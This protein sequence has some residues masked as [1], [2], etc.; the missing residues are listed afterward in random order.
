VGLNPFDIPR[1]FPPYKIRV[2]LV[3]I[4]L[5]APLAVY[6]P[7]FFLFRFIPCHTFPDQLPIAVLLY[8]LSPFGRRHGVVLMLYYFRFD[9]R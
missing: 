6:T 7:V 2:Q 8:S 1:T 3:P 5:G 9:P 4:L